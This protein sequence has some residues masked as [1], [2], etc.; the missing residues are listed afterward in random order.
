MRN[1][2]TI[3]FKNNR[4]SVFN[5][6]A[7]AEEIILE[8]IPLDT[9]K[10]NFRVEIT[11]SGGGVTTS[12]ALLLGASGTIHYSIPADSW[13]SIGT[14]R[15]RLLS[16]EGNSSYVD[17]GIEE[18]IGEGDDIQV[19]GGYNGGSFTIKILN[20]NDNDTGWIVPTLGSR[21]REYTSGWRPGY[22]KK[23][24]IV[25][26]VGAVQPTSTI[27]YDEASTELTIFELPEGFRP[28]RNVVK[29]CQG[30]VRCKWLFQARTNGI[31]SFSRY[32]VG[33]LYEQAGTNA[34]LPFEAMF[35][36]D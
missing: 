35:F 25:Q 20:E 10:T 6:G 12:S 19:T 11:K 27:T 36:A 3:D 24:G 14:M 17:F 15:A 33:D 16:N 30:S 22:R 26:V 7:T 28:Y 18:A 2:C 8:I 13:R 21:F 32:H 34:W 1:I 9:Q 23:N 31:V 29:I 5:S 4:K